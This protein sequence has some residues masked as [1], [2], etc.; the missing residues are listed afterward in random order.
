[1]AYPKAS[2]FVH[3][4]EYYVA[5]VIEQDKWI[6]IPRATADSFFDYRVYATRPSVRIDNA[7]SD[8]E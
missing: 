8:M 7:L 1:L 4:D 5:A 2:K 3:G 6:E